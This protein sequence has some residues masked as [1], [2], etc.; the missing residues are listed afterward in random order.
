MINAQ[1]A[2]AP[3]TVPLAV[4]HT[5]LQPAIK[6]IIIDFLILNVLDCRL[7][8]VYPLLAPGTSSYSLLMK[9]FGRKLQKASF[10]NIR[11]LK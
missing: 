5:H 9:D 3:R 7:L 6:Y 10:F 1:V 2:D 11:R 4:P 8:L